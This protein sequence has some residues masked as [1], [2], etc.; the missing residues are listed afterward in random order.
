M[1][2]RL[3][4]QAGYL[5]EQ[6]GFSYDPQGR[7][8]LHGDCMEYFPED[9]PHAGMEIVKATFRDG[10]PDGQFIERDQNSGAIRRQGSFR[11]GR[12]DGEWIFNDSEGDPVARAQFRQGEL[13]GNVR[14]YFTDG[15]HNSKGVLRRELQVEG[16]GI[17][18]ITRFSE[19][20][21]PLESITGTFRTGLSANGPIELEPVTELRH[22]ASMNVPVSSLLPR[23]LGVS[24]LVTGEHIRFY[25]AERGE[26]VMQSEE[27][28]RDGILHGRRRLYFPD[29]RLGVEESVENGVL[30]GPCKAWFTDGQQS[31]A[32]SF[33][34][35]V[36]HGQLQY[37]TGPQ[38]A[39]QQDVQVSR[40]YLIGWSVSYSAEGKR[41]QAAH[42]AFPRQPM[43]RE[44]LIK[45]PVGG[46]SAERPPTW[47]NPTY[48]DI[49]GPVAYYA[50]FE[51][52]PMGT[53]QPN[54]LTFIYIDASGQRNQTS[55]VQEYLEWV[56]QDSSLPTDVPFWPAL[57]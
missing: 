28:I 56:K 16:S 52:S 2:H 21:A 34:K 44:S 51:P 15:Y 25:K 53:A 41:T 57:E 50:D 42:Y 46:V 27:E 18:A 32:A 14:E 33:D 5:L 38:H 55:S 10:L 40:G 11:L 3:K 6:A 48:G 31:A 43:S 20:G 29:G 47:A 19:S 7:R 37:R 17:K 12:P 36:L 30:H 13:E 1:A 24:D 9:S 26:P 49:H 22:V 8:L 23:D 45:R 39:M 35:G 4:T 54:T